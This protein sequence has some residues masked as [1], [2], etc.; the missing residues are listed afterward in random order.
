MSS[1][2]ERGL[3]CSVDLPIFESEMALRA[4]LGLWPSGSGSRLPNGC[5]LV[6][7]SVARGDYTGGLRGSVSRGRGI[8]PGQAMKWIL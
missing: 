2:E 4:D 8:V 5:D 6:S 3:A 7:C 1:L